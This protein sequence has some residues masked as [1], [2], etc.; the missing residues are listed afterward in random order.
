MNFVRILTNE[1]GVFRWFYTDPESDQKFDQ[2]EFMLRM[3][4]R[5]VARRLEKKHTRRKRRRGTFEEELDKFGFADDCLDH[6]IV[7]WKGV[8]G[9]ELKEDGSYEESDLPCTRDYKL[10]LGEGIKAEIARKCFGRNASTLLD[11][12]DG[13][14]AGEDTQSPPAPKTPPGPKTPQAS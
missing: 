5:D 14:F 10:A 13:D 11:D 3:L 9:L 4:S 6:C 12:D 7:D 1:S 8:K 2:S